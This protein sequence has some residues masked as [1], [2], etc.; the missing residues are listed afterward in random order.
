MASTQNDRLCICFNFFNFLQDSHDR[1]LKTCPIGIS[2][3]PSGVNN[4]VFGVWADRDFVCNS[5]FGPYEGVIVNKQDMELMTVAEKTLL[6]EVTNYE[7]GCN[8]FFLVINH[9]FRS[10]LSWVGSTA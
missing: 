3:R 1:A 4:G 10:P 9:L 8:V 7:N 6:K 5:L 2:I